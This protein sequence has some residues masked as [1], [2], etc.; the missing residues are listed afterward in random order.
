MYYLELKVV[1]SKN[2]LFVQYITENFPF[3]TKRIKFMG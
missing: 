2:I 1:M 3:S